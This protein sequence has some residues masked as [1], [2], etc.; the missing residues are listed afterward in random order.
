MGEQSLTLTN[1]SSTLTNLSSTLTLLQT[2]RTNITG[3]ELVHN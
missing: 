1:L 3:Y 2:I